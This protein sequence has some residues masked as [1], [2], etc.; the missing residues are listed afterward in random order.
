LAPALAEAFGATL[1]PRGSVGAKVA[2]V[3]QGEADVYIHA[4][5]QYQWDSAA[6]VAVAGHFGLHASRLDGSPLT[7]GGQDLRVDDLV[8]CAPGNADRVL[9]TIRD[10]TDAH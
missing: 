3:I 4:G 9:E 6:P 7:Y 1:V 10:V 8:V 2:G 5:G